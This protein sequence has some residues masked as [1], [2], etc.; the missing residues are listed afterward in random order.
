MRS[1]RWRDALFLL[2]L[3]SG[4]DLLKKLLS[5]DERALPERERWKKIEGIFDKEQRPN[6]KEMFLL[7]VIQAIEQPL[8]V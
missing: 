3:N 2:Y 5:G 7:F 1:L 4:I 6:L 8:R